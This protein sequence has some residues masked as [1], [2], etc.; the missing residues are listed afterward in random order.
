MTKQYWLIY[1]FSYSNSFSIKLSCHSDFP[2]IWDLEALYAPNLP[3]THNAQHDSK[4]KERP[5]QSSHSVIK[6]SEEN[7]WI[8]RH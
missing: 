2:N 6:Q 1:P 4:T 7:I 5:E 3:K 8:F